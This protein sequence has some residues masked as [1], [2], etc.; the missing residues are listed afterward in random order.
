MTLRYADPIDVSPEEQDL[1][2][3]VYEYFWSVAV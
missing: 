2:F 1:V 3:R